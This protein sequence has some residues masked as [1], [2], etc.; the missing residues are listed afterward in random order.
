[1]TQTTNL[2]FRTDLEFEKDIANIE[3]RNFLLRN[4]EFEKGISNMVYFF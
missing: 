1:M 4:Y 3:M 2:R